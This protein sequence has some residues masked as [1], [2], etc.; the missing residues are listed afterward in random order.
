MAIENELEEIDALLSGI[1]KDVSGGAEIEAKNELGDGTKT[2]P[3]LV[4]HE[5]A[6][7][8]S[9]DDDVIA[10]FNEKFPGTDIYSMSL[11]ELKHLRDDVEAL[12]EEYSLIE[13]AYKVLSNGA[14]GASANAKGFYFYN[15]AVAGDIT[16]ECRA[17]TKYFWTHLEE[18]F[19]KTI[20]ER[21]D[22]WEKFG[23]ELDESKKALCESLPVS[24]YSDTDSVTEDSVIYIKESNNA[25]MAVTFKEFYYILKEKY[26]AKE[27]D[28]VNGQTIIAVPGNISVMNI[29]NGKTEYSPV[30]YLMRHKVSKPL[31]I[32][33][34]ESGKRV[35]VTE[36]HSCVVM[37]G[38]KQI[39]VKAADI[40]AETDTLICVGD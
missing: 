25:P 10:L 27:R 39:T 17:L 31:Y 23:F 1:L 11:E 33:E 7:R 2:E 12:R 37:R 18:F 26:K 9:W 4:V 38:G 36:D 13:L 3:S 40:N 22:L 8:I 14:Y 21:K 28:N 32:I 15:L 5:G 30:K 29:K 24:C 19:H 35:T 20:W 6:G 16:G 34:T